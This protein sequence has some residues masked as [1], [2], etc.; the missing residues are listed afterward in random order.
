MLENKC[1]SQSE[2]RNNEVFLSVTFFYALDIFFRYDDKKNVLNVELIILDKKSLVK[3]LG[4]TQLD[5]K[6][7]KLNSKKEKSIKILS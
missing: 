1:L 6:G 2:Q 3:K 5:L 4:L 7:L